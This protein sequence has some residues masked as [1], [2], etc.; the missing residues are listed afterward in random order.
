MTEQEVAQCEAVAQEL[1]LLIDQNI[2]DLTS[3]Q[4]RYV[5]QRVKTHYDNTL[6]ELG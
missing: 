5:L 4:R 3:A 1:A 6:V 2:D